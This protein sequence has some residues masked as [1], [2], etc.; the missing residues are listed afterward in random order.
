MGDKRWYAVQESRVDAWDYG[1][2]DYSTAVQML[3][4]QGHG[5]IAVINENTG[6]CVEEIE[7]DDIEW[8]AEE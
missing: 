2:D 6:C 8:G 3:K 4:K 5:L 1:S 7:F